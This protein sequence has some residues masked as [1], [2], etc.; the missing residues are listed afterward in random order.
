MRGFLFVVRHG[1]HPLLLAVTAIETMETPFQSV[2]I[3]TTGDEDETIRDN[4]TAIGG[5]G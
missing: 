1:P 3:F 2:I 5:L 4:G